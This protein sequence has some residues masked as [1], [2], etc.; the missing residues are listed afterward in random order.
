MK[1]VPIP[2]GTALYK[3]QAE[4]GRCALRPTAQGADI[5]AL[6]IAPA[7]RRRGYGSYLLK[8][9]LRR[10]GGY[11]RDEASI[12]T[13]PLPQDPGEQAFWAKFGFAPQGARLV[14]RRKP[15]LTAVQLVHDYLAAQLRE[16]RFCID[17]TCGN[18]GDTEFL[19]RLVGTGGQVLGMDVQPQ[20]IAATRA[21][22]QRAGFDETRCTL[23]CDDH[24]R[25]MSYA[26]PGSADAVLFNF[27]WLP[28]A[29][30]DVFSTAASSLPALEAAL[31]VLRPG[32]ILSAVLYSGRV[33]GT[34][35][36]QAVLNWLHGLPIERYTVL[37]CT[38][39]NW[40]ETAPLPCFVLKK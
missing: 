3:E 30:H 24:A 33:I 25:L 31:E 7:W 38:F 29:P 34:D 37:I 5:E 13:A 39:G 6:V 12:F 35:E 17:A 27:G 22:L 28:G 36:K 15:D 11:A 21:R 9:I 32:G 1:L 14:R 18:G 26:A 20:A 23:V 2:G 10:N 4:I 40:A 19:C 16:P 8:E